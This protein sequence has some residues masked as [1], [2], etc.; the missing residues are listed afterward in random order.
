MSMRRTGFTTSRI[1]TTSIINPLSNAAP[2]TSKADTN[3]DNSGAHLRSTP[4]PCR[5]WSRWLVAAFSI[6]ILLTVMPAVCQAAD[7]PDGLNGA[8]TAWMMV[9]A[10]LVLGLHRVGH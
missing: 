4:P 10:G 1:H 9:A 5:R 6:A 7:E 8:D 2:A 3:I